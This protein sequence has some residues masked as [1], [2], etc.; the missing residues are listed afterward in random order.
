MKCQVR[1]ATAV[2]Q[3]LKISAL[4]LAAGS[5]SRMGYR[6]KCLLER[7]GTSLIRHLLAA[8]MTS[9]VDSISLVLGHYADSIASEVA[10]LPVHILRNADPQA[11]Q[12]SSLR[13]G[14]A[15][16]PAGTEAVIVTLADQPLIGPHEI[17]E[18][19]CAYKN[20]PRDVQ[21]VQPS[22]DGLPGNPVI[23]SAE[24]ATDILL[25]HE[26]MGCRQ[27]QMAHPSQSYAWPTTNLNYR[28]DVDSE[29]DIDAVAHLSGHQF[30]WPA[31]LHNGA[32][33]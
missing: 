16:I 33:E 5:G 10:E 6:P 18:L 3:N 21:V 30:K 12:T 27:W 19:I 1:Q 13:L 29:A 31:A 28:L 2:S 11:G 8:L 17:I 32:S 15:A 20:R 14:L 4:V 24:V 22:V 25:G 26:H 7:D 23:L 9:G